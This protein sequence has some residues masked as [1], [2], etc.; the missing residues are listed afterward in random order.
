MEPTS[1]SYKTAKEHSRTN[2]GAPA[3]PFSGPGRWSPASAQ[4]PSAR[5]QERL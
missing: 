2:G 1:I 5:P 3:G 4:L